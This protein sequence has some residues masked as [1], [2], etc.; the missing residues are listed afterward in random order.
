MTGVELALPRRPIAEQFFPAGAEL[1]DQSFDEPQGV[2]A[3]DVGVLFRKR[4]THL[5]IQ[6]W[7]LQ[8]AHC[9]FLV[10]RSVVRKFCPRNL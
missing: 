6:R 10:E 7:R 4:R 3:E 2:D 5:E 9:T 1:A 8:L